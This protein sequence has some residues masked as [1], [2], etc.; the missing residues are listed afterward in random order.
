MQFESEQK[1]DDS[2]EHRHLPR[3]EMKLE[4]KLSVKLDISMKSMRDLID[5]AVAKA[6]KVKLKRQLQ[7]ELEHCM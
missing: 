1:L 7:S 6:I 4:Q 2:L 3:L 5:V